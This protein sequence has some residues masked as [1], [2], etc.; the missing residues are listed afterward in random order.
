ME[1]FSLREGIKKENSTFRGHKKE[2]IHFFS[3]FLNL[4]IIR[5]T[6]RGSTPPPPDKVQFFYVCGSC[7]VSE[8]KCCALQYIKIKN[9]GV[10][11]AKDRG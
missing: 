4:Y 1:K 9:I 8:G 7:L 3:T 5:I 10:E 2:N 6:D 11:E